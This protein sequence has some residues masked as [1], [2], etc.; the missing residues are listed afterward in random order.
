MILGHGANQYRLDKTWGD[1]GTGKY[2][3]LDCQEMVI[4]AS[5][6]IY[7]LTNDVSNNIL[8]YNKD[9]EII[10]SWGNEYPGAHGLSIHNENGTECLFICDIERHQVIKTTLNGRPLLVINYPKDAGVY[11]NAQQF[12]PTECVVTPGGDIYAA[13]GYGLQYVI[14]YDSKGKYL[15]HWG[16]KGNGKSEFDCAHGIAIDV[17]K[18]NNNLLITSRNHQAFKR[19]TFEGEYL[20][21]INLP[22]SFVCRPVIKGDYLYAAVFRSGSNTN[23]GSGYI[24]VLDE[25]NKVVSAPGAS[26]PL[27]V[28]NILEPQTQAVPA[29]IHP[30]DV[31]VDD[32]GNIYVCQWNSG[33]I[34]PFKLEKKR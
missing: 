21:T 1:P 4:D 6:L 8:V 18:G 14:H 28:N 34:F 2:T 29:F 33:K 26:E 3:V 5:G 25:N 19:F 20:E 32:E 12:L 17:R 13:D 31:C 30:H 15:N 9:G 7:L 11:E 22:G 10:K 23:F 27:Y 24:L 16:G